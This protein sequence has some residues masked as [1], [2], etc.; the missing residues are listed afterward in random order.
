M[1]LTAPFATLLIQTGKILHPLVGAQMDF[2]M[3]AFLYVLSAVFPVR[4]A[5]ILLKTVQAVLMVL[6]VLSLPSAPA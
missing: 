3:Q 6:V 4:T 1:Q 5:F 2:S